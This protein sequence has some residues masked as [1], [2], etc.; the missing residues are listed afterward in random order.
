[1]N[2]SVI[3]TEMLK[4][5]ISFVL[6]LHVMNSRISGWSTRRMPMLAPLLFH[7]IHGRHDR[8]RFNGLY[9]VSS[10]ANVHRFSTQ[11]NRPR[12]CGGIFRHVFRFETGCLTQPDCDLEQLPHEPFV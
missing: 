12:G 10:V 4:F 8:D 3:A 11:S 9:E 1:M 6:S 7:V 5:V 2:L